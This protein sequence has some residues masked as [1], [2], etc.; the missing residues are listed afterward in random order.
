[1]PDLIAPHGG[2]PLR[3][4][5]VPEEAQSE[6]RERAKSLQTVP[7]TSRET[8]DLVMLAMGAYSPL[9]GFMGEHDWRGV[10][11]DMRCADGLF[12]PIPIT[13]SAT[14]ELAS[15][16]SAGDDVALV[17]G[18][19]QEVMGVLSV[20]EVYKPEKT[21]ECREV[22]LTTDDKHPGVAKVMAQGAFNLAGAVQCVSEGIYRKQYAGLCLRPS[23]A[24][25]EFTERNWHRVAAF[26]TRNPMHRSHEYLV[27]IAIEVTDGVF[28][29]Q[30]LGKLAPGDLPAEVRVKAI[31]ALIENYFNRNSVIQGGYPI[32]MR[33]GGPREALLH[34][35]IRQ[36]F[37][38]T[39]LVVGRDHAGV[40]GYY[41]PYDAQNIFDELWDGALQLQPIRLDN[42]FYCT[43]TKEMAT[44]K[45]SPAGP[46]E[47]LSI[48]GTRLREMFTNGEEVPPEFSRPEVLEILKEFYAAQ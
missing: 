1:M 38:C 39:H 29:H 42:T 14:E 10:C 12:W 15:Q 19:S 32:E 37:G 23:E 25:K 27:R 30:V 18:E 36:N 26:Q 45:T 46:D 33:Y 43:K 31:N 5:L 47:R 24:R 16:I 21:L 11:D 35:V 22:F 34:A 40:G 3:P 9:A 8:S 20:S 48:S 17:D 6:L 2:V 7:M 44:T 28:I 13:L 41:G 4:R